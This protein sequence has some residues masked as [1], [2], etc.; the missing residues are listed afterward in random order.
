MEIRFKENIFKKE[1][2][3]GVVVLDPNEKSVFLINNTG[4]RILE[5]IEEKKD[6]EE[7]TAILKDEY[8]RSEDV[9]KKDVLF[10]LDEVKKNSEIFEFKK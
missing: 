9:I 4:K 1:T 2:G 3:E 10:F 8:E 6:I 7:I 5:L